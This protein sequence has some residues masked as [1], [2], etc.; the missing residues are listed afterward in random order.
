MPIGITE[1][2]QALHEAVRG[3]V[4]RHCPPSLP[5]ALLDAEREERPD[6]WSGLA[7]QGWLGLHLPESDG[8]SGYGIPE[9][10]VVLEELAY[11]DRYP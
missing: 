10:V 8:G 2:H 6:F 3:W 1:D 7:D 11:A 9:L 5:R 4:Q